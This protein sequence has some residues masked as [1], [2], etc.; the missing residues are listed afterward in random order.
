[1]SPKAWS[2][3]KPY[4]ST[5]AFYRDAS[6]FF[7]ITCDAWNTNRFLCLAFL[8]LFDCLFK[9]HLFICLGIYLL[10]FCIYLS[11]YLSI[12][13]FIHVSTCLYTHILCVYTYAHLSK[14]TSESE[15]TYRMFPLRCGNQPEV[16]LEEP[17][18]RPAQQVKKSNR[19]LCS[20]QSCCG[21]NMQEL[22]LIASN[23]Q[24]QST[25]SRSTVNHPSKKKQMQQDAIFKNFT[26]CTM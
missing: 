10:V 24:N 6:R 18:K 1:M 8:C 12:H 14:K 20:L 26:R 11:V 5:I 17:H 9:S 19:S 7:A 4:S 23:C 2:I 21:K 3:T 16:R 22:Y 13:V 15:V 25:Y